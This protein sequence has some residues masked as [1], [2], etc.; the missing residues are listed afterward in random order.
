[1]SE[2]HPSELDS[3]PQSRRE[4][5]N[6]ASSLVLPLALVVA[7]V[8][9]LL[10]FETRSGGSATDSKGY[11]T[12][13]LPADRNPTGQSPVAQQ[14]R[15][16][17]DFV[18]PDLNGGTTRLSDL[19]GSPVVVNFWA[20]W[21]DACRGDLVSLADT[22][23]ADPNGSLK[24]LAVNLQDSKDA[25]GAYAGDFS[26]PFTVLLDASGEVSRTWRIDGPTSGLPA[27]YFIDATGV[28]RQVTSGP[29][30]D[31]SLKQ[32]LSL[33]EGGN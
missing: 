32:G 11:G 8:G 22:V 28:V 26:L 19:Q 21:C 29:L 4:W 5:T 17:P 20:T 27:T 10:Y 31:A 2:Q 6:W 12:V 3:R 1:M 25:A 23:D 14:G 18:L 30:T 7:I 15:A 16:A 13:E 33:I 24:V 9:L